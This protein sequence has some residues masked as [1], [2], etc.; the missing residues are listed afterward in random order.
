MVPYGIKGTIKEIRDAEKKADEM[1]QEAKRQSLKISQEADEASKK[2]YADMVSEAQQKAEK[3]RESAENSEKQRT[4]EALKQT[5]KE[6]ENMK[7]AAIGRKN[8]AVDLII[9]EL[10]WVQNA[11]EEAVEIKKYPLKV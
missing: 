6:I 4:D 10:I 9:S 5:E 1:V 11:P 2:L 7:A 3:L 8:E